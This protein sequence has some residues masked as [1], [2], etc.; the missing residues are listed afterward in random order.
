MFGRVYGWVHFACMAESVSRVWLS[1]FRV[2]SRVPIR[3]YGWVTF[4]VYGWGQMD[5][6]LKGKEL[7]W[8][9]QIWLSGAHSQNSATHTDLTHPRTQIWLS[10]A[11]RSDS[12]AHTNLTHLRTQSWLSHTHMGLSLFFTGGTHTH[13]SKDSCGMVFSQ[14]RP[15][16][17]LGNGHCLN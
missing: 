16:C 12:P 10:G 3:V 6:L 7:M 9:T 17:I 4:R 14:A 1:C 5:A 11:H 8:C 13:T 2:Y 15:E